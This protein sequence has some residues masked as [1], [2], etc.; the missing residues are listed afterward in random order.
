MLKKAAS[1]A[2]ASRLVDV[3]A[4]VRHDAPRRGP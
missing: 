1:M 2:E 3:D 4:D